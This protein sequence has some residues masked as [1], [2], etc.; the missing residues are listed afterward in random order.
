MKIS[1]IYEKIHN[2]T[3]ELC[4]E[5]NIE[6]LDES[7]LALVS[8]LTRFVIEK[9]DLNKSH[10]HWNVLHT[11][12]HF[13]S[14]QN[15]KLSVLK[16]IVFY[17]NNSETNFMPVI[18]LLGEYIKEYKDDYWT[19]AD[20]NKS[21]QKMTFHTISSRLENPISNIWGVKAYAFGWKNPIF[22]YSLDKIKKNKVYE[23]IKKVYKNSLGHERYFVTDFKD[24]SIYKKPI[25]ISNENAKY[26]NAFYETHPINHKDFKD[27][28][29]VNPQKF[30]Y[31]KNDQ[32]I[33]SFPIKDIPLNKKKELISKVDDSAEIR[34]YEFR[35]FL[36]KSNLPFK[37]GFE[38]LS[39]DTKWTQF[40]LVKIGEFVTNSKSLQICRHFKSIFTS[41]LKNTNPYFLNSYY[42]KTLTIRPA[43]H[44]KSTAVINF[45][46]N[47]PDKNFSIF[48]PT[49]KANEVFAE[50]KELNNVNI[51]TTQ[52]LMSNFRSL[53]NSETTI[54][55]RII[56]FDEISM[57]ESDWW[58]NIE[59]LKDFLQMNFLGDPWQIPPIFE[60]GF[61]H[62]LPEIAKKEI[63]TSN[64]ILNVNHRLDKTTDNYE[65]NSL[66]LRHI[67]EEKINIKNAS[68][69]DLF[70]SYDGY[71]EA[72]K[73]ILNEEYSDYTII[74]AVNNGVLSVNNLNRVKNG[75]DFKVGDYI[76]WNSD[77]GPN[78]YPGKKDKIIKI[79][80]S[81]EIIEYFFEG[82]DNSYKIAHE[83]NPEFDFIKVL[84]GHRSQGQTLKNVLVIITDTELIDV[85]WLYTAASRAEKNILILYP[86]D[87]DF[88]KLKINKK[89]TTIEIEKLKKFIE[90][91]N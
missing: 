43:G 52:K 40:S 23:G 38:I 49:R 89:L 68:Y 54:K 86:I 6:E 91:I 62:L 11:F 59:Q 53:K 73:L 71:K 16:S 74:A 77:G 1:N 7:L 55:N 22:M 47:N 65:K 17:L 26:I 25:N 45:I 34:K 41:F 61:V 20:T 90:Q 79:E 29:E 50:L 8:L 80:K 56:F 70:I 58:K 15:S 83:E 39:S 48:T 76:I 69:K 14:T 63:L 35:S 75:S 57:Y 24:V 46:K 13:K 64:K 78:F 33:S 5:K 88:N 2:L 44:G 9:E 85:R 36:N 28:G 81:I 82:V 66:L 30:Y 21:K 32:L 31:I 67:R 87:F 19:W 84:S 37:E 18:E 3:K 4:E 12:L 72:F 27:I 51:L 10:Y 42:N 60:D